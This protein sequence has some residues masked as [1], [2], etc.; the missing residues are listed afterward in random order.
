MHVSS[1]WSTPTEAPPLVRAA[2]VL[3]KVFLIGQVFERPY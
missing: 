1:S 3:Y 2:T